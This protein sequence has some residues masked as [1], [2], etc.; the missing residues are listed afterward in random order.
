MAPAEVAALLIEEA[1]ISIEAVNGEFVDFDIIECDENGMTTEARDKRARTRAR[2]GRMRS[3]RARAP[4]ELARGARRSQSS[5]VARTSPDGRRRRGEE[6][7]AARDETLRERA[8]A[9]QI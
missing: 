6:A 4:A 5:R 7:R 8:Q 2:R 9:S 3:V 1:V